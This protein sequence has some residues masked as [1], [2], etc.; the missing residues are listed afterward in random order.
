MGIFRCNFAKFSWE[1]APGNPRMVVPSALPL[2]LI[3]GPQKLGPLGNFQ[4]TPVIAMIC[5][6]R[7]WIAMV[8]NET[9][10]YDFTYLASK[11]APS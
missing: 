10:N 2:K 9:T 8:F 7:R 1:H 6:K 3:C 5:K 11:T 4:R